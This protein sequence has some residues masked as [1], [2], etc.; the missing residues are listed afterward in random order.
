[1]SLLGKN[2]IGVVLKRFRAGDRYLAMRDARF[3]KAPAC[4]H[5]TSPDFGAW[6]MMPVAF[7]QDGDN[8]S[9]PLHWENLPSDTKSLALIVQDPDAPTSKPPVHAV[10]WGIDPA[11]FI[12]TGD[13]LSGHS[14]SGLKLGKGSFGQTGY[15]GPR[16]IRSHGRHRYVFQLFAL[17]AP[18]EVAA[19]ADERALRKAMAGH[20]VAR[21]ELT[22]WYERN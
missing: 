5:V 14:S 11:R 8:L 18:V 20:V 9:P 6:A 3:R 1:M 7:T 21:G 4:I 19:P 17:D 2:L 10:A 13:L 15:T 22:G 12:A 16:P